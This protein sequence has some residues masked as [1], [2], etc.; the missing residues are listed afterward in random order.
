MHQGRCHSL[1]R[2]RRARFVP[3]G[4]RHGCLPGEG[5]RVGT[6]YRFGPTARKSAGSG[7]SGLRFQRRAAGLEAAVGREAGASRRST[8][9]ETGDGP[10]GSGARLGELARSRRSVRRWPS[11]RFGARHAALGAASVQVYGPM[12]AD[13]KS[14][15]RRPRSAEP[16]RGRPRTATGKVDVRGFELERAGARSFRFQHADQAPFGRVGQQPG[17]HCTGSRWRAASG[18][19]APAG[20]RPEGGGE[21][22]SAG[23]RAGPTLRG[24]RRTPRQK[25]GE[26]CGAGS[27]TGACCSRKDIASGQ[28]GVPLPGK[29]AEVASARER[30]A[31][32][33]A[34]PGPRSLVLP[35]ES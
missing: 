11:S 3:G 16:A 23:V 27:M 28:R 21:A 4:N 10:R 7:V 15:S 8:G 30:T 29:G 20:L 32:W 18:S 17:G 13:R 25:A 24:D 6:D 5:P 35:S 22:R 9:R 14:S 33:D 26:G 19:P 12:P 34:P 1:N 2:A 31:G